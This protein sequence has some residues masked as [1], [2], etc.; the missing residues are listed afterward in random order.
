MQNSQLCEFG[1]SHCSIY[2]QLLSLVCRIW[3][4]RVCRKEW[5]AQGDQASVESGKN[6]DGKNRG[7]RV[8]LS[9]VQIWSVCCLQMVLHV[10]IVKSWLYYLS[11]LDM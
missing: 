1:L 2:V 4:A 3:S 9:T 11:E 10:R 8:E 5:P 6:G 7:K